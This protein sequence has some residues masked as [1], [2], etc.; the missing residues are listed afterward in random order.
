M[1]EVLKQG[2]NTLE[3]VF[4]LGR[5]GLGLSTDNSGTVSS[6]LGEYKRIRLKIDDELRRVKL[7]PPYSL[8]PTPLLHPVISSRT[9]EDRRA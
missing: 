5:E 8:C 7:H 4:I 6:K 1:S 9:Q 2:Q 3:T